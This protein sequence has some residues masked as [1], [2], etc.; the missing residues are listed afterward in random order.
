MKH[1]NDDE[2]IQ[3]AD[4][5]LLKTAAQFLD[6]ESD[7][8]DASTRA[9]LARARSNAAEARRKQWLQM[10]WLIWGGAGVGAAL[11]A[12]LTVLVIL[13]QGGGNG[14]DATVADLLAA[15]ERV[16]DKKSLAVNALNAGGFNQDGFSDAGA[17]SDA[18]ALNEVA[19]V[20]DADTALADDLAFIAW[21]EEN[22]DPS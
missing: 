2:S 8:L 11:A 9:A 20:D 16:F 22:H 15:Q 7:A 6:A 3:P 14:A 18:E 17:L 10:P 5:Q 12:S 4:A 13:P 19:L 21:L 1:G